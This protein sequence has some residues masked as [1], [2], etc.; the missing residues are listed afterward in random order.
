MD[1]DRLEPW[2]RLKAVP[3]IGDLLFRRLITAVGTP[4]SVFSASKD[5]L[6][7]IQGMSPKLVEA[8]YRQKIPE[9]FLSE[10][11]RVSSVGGRILTLTDADYPSLLMEI[12]DPPPML[13]VLGRLKTQEPAVA[14]VGSR[15]ATAYGIDTT[16]R[17]CRQLAREGITVVSG[18]ARGIDTAAH[19]G[20]V[21][22]GGRTIAVTGCGLDTV[23]PPENKGL[24]RRI[25]SAGAVISEFPM[26]AGPDPHHFPRRNRII[27][28]L[29]MGVV[30]VEATLRSGSLITAKT[31]LD[32]GRE[33][34]AVPGS[35]HSF[36]STGTHALIKQG[37]CLV[38]SVSD[39]LE[40]LPMLKETVSSNHRGDPQ[41]MPTPSVTTEEARILEALGP[42]EMQFDELARKLAMPAGR[43]SGLLLNLELKGAV[44]QSAGNH[45]SKT[46]R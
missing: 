40:E 11:K 15:N 2:F 30:V 10:V 23:Y 20:A 18:M 43:L 34:F 46:N 45:Y 16:R 31:A 24:F 14:V 9:N 12:D 38:E 25:A 36:K 7:G 41:E 28:G 4:E 22:G 13:Y 5:V 26:G 3:G 1:V 21:D 27:S 37:A 32:Q 44:H 33:V 39:I 8:I 6:L 35:I 42:C 17:L 19:E 29:G